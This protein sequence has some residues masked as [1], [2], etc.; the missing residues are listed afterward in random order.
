VILRPKSPNRSCQETRTLHLLVQGPNRTRCHPTFRS[1]G[2]R[3]PNLCLTIIDPVHQVPY[4]F[5]DPYRCPSCRTCHL[6]TTGQANVILHTNQDKGKNH[7]NV[8]NSNSN[9]GK[10]MTHHNQ[11]KIL[12]S[13]FLNLP[14]DESINNKKHKV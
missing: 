7:R 8:L 11:T 2:H 5:L 10:P 4:S 9:H 14:L 1:S 3:V 13:W 6:H 12:T